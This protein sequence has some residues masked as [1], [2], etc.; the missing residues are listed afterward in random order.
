M[1]EAGLKQCW[2]TLSIRLVSNCLHTSTSAMETS[3]PKICFS[4]TLFFFLLLSENVHLFCLFPLCI[5][6]FEM[7]AGRNTLI[8]SS[9][10]SIFQTHVFCWIAVG[11]LKCF[12]RCLVILEHCGC[13]WSPYRRA[14]V[15]A[16]SLWN[17]ETQCIYAYVCSRMCF[18]F[19]SD[20]TPPYPHII[21]PRFNPSPPLC[22][23]SFYPQFPLGMW[24]VLHRL[25]VHT[26][27]VTL[28]I[29]GSACLGSSG[30]GE[31]QREA[32]ELSHRYK[33]QQR[34]R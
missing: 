32:L 33:N 16:C 15:S 26:A 3:P 18:H 24:L 9:P 1:R 30:S 25:F 17:N 11:C 10:P 6:L 8:W 2:N 20:S 12:W 27:Q 19:V 5:F 22:F 28:R 14:C 13:D 34:K 4:S 31:R 7:R 29:E 23:P 21:T